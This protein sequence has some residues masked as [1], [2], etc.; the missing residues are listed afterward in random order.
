MKTLLSLLLCSLLP[1]AQAGPGFFMN[2]QGVVATSSAPDNTPPVTSGLVFFAEADQESYGNGDAVDSITDLSGNGFNATQGTAA[3]RPTFV[4][5]VV[6]GRSAYRLD[7]VDDF[8]AFSR[9]GLDLFRNRTGYSVY[10]VS[11]TG[12][13]SSAIKSLV[14]AS[15]NSSTGLLR[16]AVRWNTGAAAQRPTASVHPTIDSVFLMSKAFYKN[17]N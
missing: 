13:S 14:Y 8:A 4:T 1:A 16:A 15:A 10:V 12:T 6:N 7:G 17:T 2:Q 3:S 9:S 11:T 5:G